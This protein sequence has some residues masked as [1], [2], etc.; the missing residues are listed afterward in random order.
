[1]CAAQAGPVPG[2]KNQEYR[3]ELS[4][5]LQNSNVQLEKIVQGRLPQGSYTTVNVKTLARYTF[6][7]LEPLGLETRLITLSVSKVHTCASFLLA[8][9]NGFG[10]VHGDTYDQSTDVPKLQEQLLQ[11]I[12]NNDVDRVDEIQKAYRRCTDIDLYIA[13]DLSN[14]EIQIR[15]SDVVLTAFK[16]GQALKMVLPVLLPILMNSFGAK[17]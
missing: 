11:R 3:S 14:I 8:L 10:I 4:K 16:V 12:C 1:M 13:S 6:S 15:E 17:S 7:G 2:P 9:F 5:V